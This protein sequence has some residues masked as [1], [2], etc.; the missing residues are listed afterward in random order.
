MARPDLSRHA[1]HWEEHSVQVEVPEVARDFHP[2]VEESDD[3]DSEVQGHADVVA[4]LDCRH[5]T[6]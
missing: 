1:D 6:L 2:V 4:L 5:A 3:G